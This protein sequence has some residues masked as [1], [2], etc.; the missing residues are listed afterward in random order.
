MDLIPEDEKIFSGIFI[1]KGTYL[2]KQDRLIFKIKPKTIKIL[3]LLKS[4]LNKETKNNILELY[5][6][7]NFLN[8]KCFKS[9]YLGITKY[10]LIDIP[11][12]KN[13]TTRK[14]FGSIIQVP[15]ELYKLQLL[16]NE[17]YDLLKK[18]DFEK[19]SELFTIESVKKRT[20]K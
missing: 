11:N 2:D 1:E 12:F 14:G 5:Y 17:E 13:I 19:L 8:L 16:L 20:R 6:N 10:Y 7:N 15:E 4:K 3:Y 18:D 9:N